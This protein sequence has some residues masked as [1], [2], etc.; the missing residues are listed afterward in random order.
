EGFKICAL[1]LLRDFRVEVRARSGSWEITPRLV[2]MRFGRELVY[3]VRTFGDSDTLNGSSVEIAGADEA[4]CKA[5]SNARHLFRHPE[6]PLLAKP[7]FVDE[8]T[9]VGVYEASDPKRGDIFYRKQ[10][11]GRLPFSRGGALT[12]AC[13]EVVDGLA[14]DRDRRNLA[15]ARRLIDRVL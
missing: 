12:F 5:F 3:D 9:G 11:R 8:A 14:P 1:V 7:L 13:D 6:N 15:S 10:H 2:P 4:L